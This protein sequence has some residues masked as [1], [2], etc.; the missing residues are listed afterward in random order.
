MIKQLLLLL[1]LLLASL[2]VKSQDFKKVDAL[3]K[4]YPRF[5]KVVLLANK[6]S[7][8]FTTDEE[9]ARA[10]F[11]WLAI[12]IR[13]NL[14]EYD[15]P[16]LRNYNL[17]YTTE[18]EKEHKLQALKDEITAKTFFNKTGVCEEY[19]QSFKKIC[20]LLGIEAEVIKGHVRNNAS[21][22][23]RT[24]KTSNHAWNAV[25][26]NEKWIVLD[27]TWAAGYESNGKWRRKF[28]NYFYNI[29]KEKIFK[30]HF[31]DDAIWVLRFGRMSLDEFY[32]QAIYGNALLR[33]KAELLSP[34]N[35]IIR[36]NKK[37]NIELKFKNLD[38]TSF[39]YYTFTGMKN[40]QKPFVKKENGVITLSIKN[41]QKNSELFLFID[42]EL[43]L[44]FRTK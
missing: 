31:P 11:Y 44:Q 17:S 34:K 38:T 10:A 1:F 7:T 8:D 27:P 19:A 15:N 35:G 21:E 42:Q 18:A 9:K 33:S 13:Y 40:A 37:E 24:N 25:K 4:T 3:V 28:D 2:S 23:D 6:I 29:P 20:S 30:T 32:K 16:T 26:L 36:I 12:N 39:I 41:P 14:K 43:A 22:I 5:S